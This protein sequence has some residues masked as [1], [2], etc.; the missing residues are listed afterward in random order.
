MEPYTL[1]VIARTQS[2]VKRLRN[3]LD[4]GQYVLRWV[5]SS[6]QALSLNVSLSLII[7][8]LPPSGGSRSIVRL[9]QGYNAPILAIARTGQLAPADVEASLVR[10]FRANALV[11]LIEATLIYHSPLM[12]RAEGMSLDPATRRLHLDGVVHQLRPIASRILALLMVRAG[13][14][15]S[16]DELFRRV[17]HTADTDSTRA[18]DVHIAQ[19]R[20]E[21][22]P[23]PKKPSVILTERG[24]GYRLQAPRSPK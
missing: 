10:P 9:K 1:L 21:I 14:A 23:D 19:L 20:R 15:I 6:A 11:E 17:W 22:E 24:V 4:P 18:L 8:E 16:R 2:L 3:V 7:L 5:P 12:I 13:H